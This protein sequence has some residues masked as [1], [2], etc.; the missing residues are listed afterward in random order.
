MS[1]ICTLKFSDGFVDFFGNFVYPAITEPALKA[2][3]T[4]KTSRNK[5]T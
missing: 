4:R 2:E 5:L 3:E 1:P